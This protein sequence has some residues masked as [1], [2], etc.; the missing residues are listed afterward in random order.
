MT[1]ALLVQVLLAIIGQTPAI[2]QLIEKLKA[3]GRDTLTDDEVAQLKTAA[4]IAHQMMLAASGQPSCST[5]ATV[6][7][8]PAAS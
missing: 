6:V 3:D 4:P 1:T 2:A 7:K 5:C 8:V